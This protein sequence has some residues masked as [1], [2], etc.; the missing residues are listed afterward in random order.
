M[1]G[2]DGKGTDG[3]GR[4]KDV[5]QRKGREAKSGTRKDG[6]GIKE[7]G[8]T[9]CAI[10]RRNTHS[11][12]KKMKMER[13]RKESKKSFT[14]S[15]TVASGLTNRRQRAENRDTAV[16][17]TTEPIGSSKFTSHSIDE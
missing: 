3:K 2:K 15:G 14:I 6:E 10:T 4:E 16:T 8:T 11:S 12:Q 9:I 7:K 17:R 5:S 13:M 1:K